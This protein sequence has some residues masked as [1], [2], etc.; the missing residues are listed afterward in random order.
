MRA[1]AVGVIWRW[2]RMLSTSTR[3][4]RIT[5][6]HLS[7][8]LTTR[9]LSLLLLNHIANPFHSVY[10]LPKTMLYAKR[11][12]LLP[13]PREIIRERKTHPAYCQIQ[14]RKQIDYYLIPW[15]HPCW[16]LPF[17]YRQPSLLLNITPTPHGHTKH[18]FIIRKPSFWT[19]TKHSYIQHLVR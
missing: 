6:R 11:Y 2:M 1:K 8:S 3:S 19:L 12:R 10:D 14:L 4:P 7:T 17:R 9:S 18:P 13:I 16:I 15:R 5:T